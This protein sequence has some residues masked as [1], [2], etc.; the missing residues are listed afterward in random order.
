MFAPKIK[1]SIHVLHGTSVATNI[2]K[3]DNAKTDRISFFWISLIAVKVQKSRIVLYVNRVFIVAENR[4]FIEEW[5]QPEFGT[6][7][8]LPVHFQ[9]AYIYL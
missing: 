7:V 9:E 4:L 1:L 5:S 6:K 2:R 3:V 8:L